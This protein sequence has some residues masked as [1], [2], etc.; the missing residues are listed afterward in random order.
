MS[1][2]VARIGGKG[3]LVALDRFVK[4]SGAGQRQTQIG[5]DGGVHGI[6][7]VI[8]QGYA[9][10]V[11][12]V[13]S[14]SFALQREAEVI[15]GS[16]VSGIEFDGFAEMRDRLILFAIAVEAGALVYLVKKIGQ[17][18]FEGIPGAGLDVDELGKIHRAVGG[19]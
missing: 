6:V 19:G 15:M 7:R 14:L 2:G 11:D 1:P 16:G 17:R 8:A 10:F 9:V 12:G 13:G 5:V 4:L 3:L 18:R